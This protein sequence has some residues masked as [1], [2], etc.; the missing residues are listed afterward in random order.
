MPLTVF[1]SASKAELACQ[2]MK[3]TAPQLLEQKL[4]DGVINEPLG[5]AHRDYGSHF[6]A[7]NYRL[8]EEVDMLK[9]IPTDKLIKQR[10][11]KIRKYGRFEK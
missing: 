7:V 10:F 11:D 6:K 2:S 8:F 1:K 3:I 5:G 4:I 9:R